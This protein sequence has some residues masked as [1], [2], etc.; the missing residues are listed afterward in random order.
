M[1]AIAVF[2]KTR[3]VRLIEAP[4]PRTPPDGSDKIGE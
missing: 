3:S 2:P 4:A 1:K